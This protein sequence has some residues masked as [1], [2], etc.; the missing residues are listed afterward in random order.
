MTPVFIVE[1][2]DWF[3]K[4]AFSVELLERQGSELVNE[5][6]KMLP[7]G[8]N[9]NG[10]LQVSQYAFIFSTLISL[11]LFYHCNFRLKIINTTY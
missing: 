10:P 1:M 6:F 3:H 11:T 8:N 9:Q 4:A 7:L 5:N 2:M